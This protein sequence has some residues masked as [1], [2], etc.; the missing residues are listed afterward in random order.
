VAAPRLRDSL[1]GHLNN[2]QDP[3]GTA[4]LVLGRLLEIR[5]LTLRE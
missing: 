3:R 4:E 2:A 1:A 5:A